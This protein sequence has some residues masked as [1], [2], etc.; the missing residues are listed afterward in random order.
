MLVTGKAGKVHPAAGESSLPAV[1]GGDG[2]RS[3]GAGEMIANDFPERRDEWEM[4]ALSSL[5]PVS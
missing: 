2:G 4:R 5:L 3:S 1:S